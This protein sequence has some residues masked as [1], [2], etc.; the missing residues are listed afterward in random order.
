MSSGSLGVLQQ[1]GLYKSREER[2]QSRVKAL[3]ALAVGT[4]EEHEVL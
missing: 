2:Y 1:N 3:E 4:T